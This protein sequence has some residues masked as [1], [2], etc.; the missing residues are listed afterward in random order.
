MTAVGGSGITPLVG[1]GAMVGVGVGAGVAVLVGGAVTLTAG[2]GTGVAV[3]RGTSVGGSIKRPL[4]GAGPG[5]EVP[6]AWAAG[7]PSPA[8]SSSGEAPASNVAVPARV[9]VATAASG[10]GEALPGVVASITGAVVATAW[11]AGAAGA[12]VGGAVGL[13]SSRSPQ[14]ASTSGT[15]RP[16]STSRVRRWAACPRCIRPLCCVEPEVTPPAGPRLPIP[17][18]LLGIPLECGHP[19]AV[20]ASAT[21]VFGGENSRRPIFESRYPSSRKGRGSI[22]SALAEWLGRPAS[23]CAMVAPGRKGWPN[24]GPQ[25]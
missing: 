5:A 15:K 2:L 4:V 19:G 7:E 20:E 9:G 3:S 18:Q 12:T 23:G 14:A 24:P 6:G 10:V 22:S 8:D 21:K 25:A 16:R 17:P 11:A 13:G 1:A